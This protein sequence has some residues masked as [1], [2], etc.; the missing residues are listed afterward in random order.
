MLL[1]NIKKLSSVLEIDEASLFRSFA[2]IET[3][4]GFYCKKES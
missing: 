3:S 1:W 4:G 2:N